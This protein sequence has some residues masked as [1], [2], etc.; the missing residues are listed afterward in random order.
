MACVSGEARI[1]QIFRLS[2]RPI[3]EISLEFPKLLSVRDL[4]RFGRLGRPGFR[5]SRCISLDLTG[6]WSWTDL[7]RRPSAC[8]AD[9]LPTELQP[10]FRLSCFLRHQVCYLAC[11]LV[12]YLAVRAAF[13]ICPHL[14]PIVSGEL[15]S[16]KR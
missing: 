1:I 15:D 8:K 9:A 2:T 11:W 7:N 4:R 3:C 10:H 5:L 13:R 16:V 6:K 14:Y 12:S